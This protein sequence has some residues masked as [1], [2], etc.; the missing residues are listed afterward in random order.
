MSLY[1][2]APSPW[3]IFLDDA[4]IYLP[5]GQLAIYA[6]GTTTPAIVYTSANGTAHPFPITLDATGRVPGGLYLQPGLNYKFVLHAPMIEEPLDGGII[7]S[8]DH[9][10]AVPPSR[11]GGTNLALTLPGDF[12]GIDVTGV[13]LIEYSGAGD[14]FIRGFV[15]GVPGQTLTIKNLGF[16]TIWL[17][18][19]DASAPGGGE[20]VNF[21][22]S[23][24]TPLS[25]PRGTASYTYLSSQRWGIDAHGQGAPIQGIFNPANY[26]TRNPGVTWVVEP[27]DFFTEAFFLDGRNLLYSFSLINTSIVGGETYALTRRLPAGYVMEGVTSTNIVVS[28]NGT[29]FEAA[30][31]GFADAQNLAFQ[32]LPMTTNWLP[33]VNNTDLRGQISIPIN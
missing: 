6:A 15:G 20:L 14:I 26:G 12:S 29:V 18:N 33:G 19:Q 5:N 4:G 30:V 13:N 32:R 16:S 8:Q 1:T 28:F 31:V 9:V 11:E 23:G 10:L 2:L 27:T 7:R 17:Y 22:G 24:P 3:L 25:G 21:V